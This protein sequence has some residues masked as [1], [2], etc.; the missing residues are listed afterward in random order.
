MKN[1]MDAEK[2]EVTGNRSAVSDARVR[3]AAAA[4]IAKARPTVP[5]GLERQRQLLR[6]R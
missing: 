5:D 1:V 2:P 3:A 6:A 4:A